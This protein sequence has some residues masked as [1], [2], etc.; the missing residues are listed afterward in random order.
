[1]PSFN[2]NGTLY[3]FITMVGVP[4]T[5]GQLV[6]DISRSN[7]DGVAL[8]RSARKGEEFIIRATRD[9][10]EAQLKTTVESY[11]SL[12]GQIVTWTDDHD[13]VYTNI[14]ILRVPLARIIRGRTMVGGFHGS[15]AY[16]IIE[17]QFACIDV[18]TS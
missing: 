8:Q 3:E 16:A 9:V 18:R 13:V 10:L 1:M 14:A 7:L 12:S 5:P 6:Q 11:R 4:P 2:D 15:S 17:Q